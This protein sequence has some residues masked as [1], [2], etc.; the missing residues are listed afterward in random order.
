[1]LDE[2]PGLYLNYV[3]GLTSNK[4]YLNCLF[5]NNAWYITDNTA[6]LNWGIDLT[7][8]EQRIFNIEKNLFFPM[9]YLKEV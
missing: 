2:R 7:I 4:A 5:S 3:Y 8:Y 6:F 9:N 1:M